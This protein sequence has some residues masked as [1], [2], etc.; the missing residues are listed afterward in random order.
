MCIGIS[1]SR[2]ALILTAILL[3]GC[4]GK[5]D[6]PSSSTSDD[7]VGDYRWVGSRF[8]YSNGD[9]GEGTLF[10]TS[11]LK[12]TAKIAAL[13]GKIEV[14]IPECSQIPLARSES[15]L[16]GKGF[17]CGPTDIG[18]QIGIKKETVVRFAIDLE[19]KRANLTTDRTYADGQRDCRMDDTSFIKQ[20][21][22]GASGTS[23][24]GLPGAT[25]AWTFKKATGKICRNLLPDKSD[26]TNEQ[27]HIS[28]GPDGFVYKLSDGK[29][30]IEGI[31]CTL[32]S[33]GM[34]EA[35]QCGKTR[36]PCP[37]IYVPEF[38]ATALTISDDHF[39]LVAEVRRKSDTYYATLDGALETIPAQ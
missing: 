10:W 12:T 29:I 35:I 36:V 30:Y 17:E 37:G 5:T 16:E 7:I 4:N 20:A 14:S 33:S 9:F 25:A 27:A 39:H 13:D 22:G 24:F 19:K 38:W 8:G 31:E 2:K 34:T 18:S 6:V 3:S 28:I 32:P 1:S 26:C 21:S 15:L 23:S 11:V